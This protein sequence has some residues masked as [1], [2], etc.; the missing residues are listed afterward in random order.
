MGNLPTAAVSTRPGVILLRPGIAEIDEHPS[1]MYLPTKP[2]NRG[3]CPRRICDRRRSRRAYPRGAWSRE[4]SSHEVGQHYRQL[5][6]L[7]VILQSPL[8]RS[9]SRRCRY[10]N[11]NAADIRI[12]RS[13]VRR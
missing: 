12:A 5:A 11:L 3:P 13:I 4:R 2:S 10:G 9:G 1:P 8:G 7:C 6:A